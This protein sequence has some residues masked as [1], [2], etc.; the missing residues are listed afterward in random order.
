MNENQKVN[1][2]SIILIVFF[3]LLLIGIV[4][5]VTV[6]NSKKS[7]KVSKTST[8][9]TNSTTQS[10]QVA[11]SSGAFVP[12]T[13]NIKKGTVVVW[14][15]KETNIHQIMSDPHPTHTALPLL[16]SDPLK[17]NDSFSFTF[18]KSGTFLYHDENNPLT[19]K[20]SVVVQ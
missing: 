4:F 12:Q 20:G 6:S 3:V 11:I 8:P 14:T 17:I 16:K 7:P 9:T 13:L 10:A 18:E 5:Y 2:S 1:W 15:N 19:I